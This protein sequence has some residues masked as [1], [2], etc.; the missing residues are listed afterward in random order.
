[1]TENLWPGGKRHVMEQGEHEQWNA[2]HYPGTLQ[3]CSICEEPTGRC[4][5]DALWDNDGLP[6]CEICAASLTLQSKDTKIR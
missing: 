5:E 2:S 3:L 6:L 1:M 4:D